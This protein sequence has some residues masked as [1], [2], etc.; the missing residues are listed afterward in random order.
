[1]Q[2]L[3]SDRITRNTDIGANFWKKGA[4]L[5]IHQKSRS[6]KRFRHQKLQLGSAEPD[7]NI[8]FEV[9]RPYVVSKNY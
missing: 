8:V 4:V 9:L 1:M 6:K 2:S 3:N 7:S 5:Q